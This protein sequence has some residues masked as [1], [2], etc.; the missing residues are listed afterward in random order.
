[1]RHL[2]APLPEISSERIYSDCANSYRD[3]KKRTALN[4][5]TEAVKD[6]SIQYKSLIP[7]T[8]QHFVPHSIPQNCS[9]DDFS[10]L[11]NDKFAKK[12]SIGREYYNRILSAPIHGV[13]P[14]CGVQRVTT[15]D[16]YLPKS[17]YPSLVVTPLNLIPTC[18]DCNLGKNDYDFNSPSQAP[19]H[20]YLDDLTD[21]AWLQANID[22]KQVVLF[23][24]DPPASWPAMQKER[25]E[26]HLALYNLYALYGMHAA[27]EICTHL[28]L[29]KQ[30]YETD[31]NSLIGYIAQERK[32]YE[33]I[34][35]N[36][37][38]SALYRSLE[39]NSSMVFKWFSDISV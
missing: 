32:S 23:Y 31:P 35:L 12:N 28:A 25:L 26:K 39:K 16:H 15:L 37:W 33:M 27:E 7:H 5:F 3:I 22:A 24:V 20:P 11:Y 10:R 18:R 21:A 6:D 29:W 8:I 38:R 17:K 13:C 9:P 19:L 34:E 14:I 2:P 1:M 36:S 30:L 4:S